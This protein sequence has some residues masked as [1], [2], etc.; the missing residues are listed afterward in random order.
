MVNTRPLNISAAAPPRFSWAIRLGFI[1]VIL[2]LERELISLLVQQL[3]VD[4]VMGA[5]RALHDVQHWL[6]RFVIVYAILL[7]LLMYLRGPGTI[8]LSSPARTNASARIIWAA[9]HLILLLC[10]AALSVALYGRAVSRPIAVIAIEWHTCALAA[11]MALFAAT[12][13]LSAWRE[14][15]L[16][17]GALPLYVVPPAAV[18]VLAI[19]FSQELWRPTAGLTFQLVQ[20]TLKPLIPS[21]RGDLATLTLT[22]DRFAVMVSDACSGLEGVGLILVFCTTWLWLFRREYV[23]PRALL[24]L[25]IAVLFIFILNTGRIA[26]LVL[27]GAAGYQKVAVL[28]FHSQA[29]WIAFNFAALGMAILARLNPWWHRNS[30]Q[31]CVYTEN[32]V[33]A[34]LMPLLVILAAGM[35]T[36]AL[37]GGFDFLYPLRLIGAAVV[38]IVYWR[39]YAGIDWTSSWRGPAVGAA[40]FFLW[41]GFAHFTLA[42]KP[43]P[44][45]LSS[46]PAPTRT[47]WIVCRILA[48]TITVP[49]AEE[50]A[51]RGFLLRRFV[52]T[53]FATVRYNEVGWRALAVSAVMF[54]VTHG[55]LWLPGIIA[56]LGYGLIAIK[57]RKLGEAVAAHVT[58]NGLLA[59]YV[60]SSGNWEFW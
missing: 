35:V 60:L 52:R 57:T 2:A 19:R 46:L 28:G 40:I 33:G 24:I 10:L 44:E 48:A 47:A 34:Y 13:P 17:A 55:Q 5:A 25:P 49:V 7:A 6:F 32:A 4:S 1:A 9:I 27:I 8:K 41:M 11:T 58:T 20:L 23:F 45:A 59:I 18:A 36:R 38:L 50:L 53:D 42:P 39:R 37:S 16:G 30:R 22:T 51:Y 26:A 29:G 12:A 14:T 21:L 54:G 56:G 43:M 15:L 3:P 31:S